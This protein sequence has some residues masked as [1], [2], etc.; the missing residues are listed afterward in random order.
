MWEAIRYF[1]LFVYADAFIWKLIRFNFLTKDHGSLVVKK[2]FVAYLFYN[3]GGFFAGAYTWLLEHPTIVQTLFITGFIMEGCFVVGFFTKRFDRCLL[4]MSVLLP[5]GF[6]F[7]SDAFF[8]ELTILS[9][10]L[11]NFSSLS[12]G[13]VRKV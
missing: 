11:V 2:N 8:F 13:N 7:L 4:V 1:A 10:T 5:F 3:P 9:F 12:T 6:L